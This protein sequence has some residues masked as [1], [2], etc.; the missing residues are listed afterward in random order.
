MCRSHTVVVSYQHSPHKIL[1]ECKTRET[2]NY[3][4]IMHVLSVS[5]IL[6]E[7]FTTFLSQ[8]LL[9]IMNDGIVWFMQ[10][11]EM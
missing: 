4:V 11:G 5:N 2:T 8:S 7:H 10:E 6:A 3:V 9:L 1:D